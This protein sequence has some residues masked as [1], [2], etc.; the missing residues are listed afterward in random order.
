M[1]QYGSALQC[2]K[3]IFVRVGYFVDWW[4]NFNDPRGKTGSLQKKR[5]TAHQKKNII[6]HSKYSK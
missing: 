1:W 3:H 6:K 5:I 2:F 4:Y